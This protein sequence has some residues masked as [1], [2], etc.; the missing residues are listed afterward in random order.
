MHSKEK[1]FL[2]N[3]VILFVGR[4]CTKLIQ[5]FLLPLYTA[6]LTTSEYGTVDLISTYVTI[7]VV[8]VNL[9]IENSIF[10]FIADKRGNEKNTINIVSNVVS[11]SIFQIIIFTILFLIIYPFIHIEGKIFLLLNVIA[12]IFMTTTMCVSRGIGDYKNYAI[13]SFIAASTAIVFNILFLVV[14]KLSI[15]GLLLS[16]FIS[17]ILSGLY[18]F[19]R[20]KIY[21]YINLKFLNST[22]RKEL[23]KYSLPLIPNELSWQAIKSSDKIIVVYILGK[24][25]NGILSVSLKFSTMFTEIYN[26]FNTSLTDTVVLNIKEKDGEKFITILINKIYRLF[27]SGGLLIIAIMPFVFNIFVNKAYNDSYNYIPLYIISSIVNVMVGMTSGIFIAKKNTKVIAYTSSI[28]GII[29]IILDLLLMKKIGL[30]A[31]AI[32]TIVGFIVMFIIRY[33]I[34]LKNY[35]VRIH[36]SNFIITF[37]ALILI[38]PVYYYGNLYTRLFTL[39]FTV[40]LSI[41]LN[42]VVIKQCF[43]II[44]RLKKRYI[45]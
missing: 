10:R 16:T 24:A 17:Y 38:L 34:I 36:L 1:I 31:A 21:K 25:Y 37:I 43:H 5:F 41:Y 42:K 8:L 14:I 40:I 39:I 13:S 23:L 32:S 7:L 12:S 9:Q 22:T 33:I 19:F 30:Y 28:A 6:I 3:T 26:I 2:N 4:M 35:K 15:T 18:L 44:Q 45:K 29:N 11:I 20:I 27:L